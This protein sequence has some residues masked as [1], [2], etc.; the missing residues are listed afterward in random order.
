MPSILE[1]LH[2]ETIGT[3]AYNFKGYNIQQN[4]NYCAISRGTTYAE[5]IPL[6]I[7]VLFHRLSFEGIIST[8]VNEH[9]YDEQHD[10]GILL[11][12]LKLYSPNSFPWVQMTPLILQTLSLAAEKENFQGYVVTFQIG[13]IG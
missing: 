12:G 5:C 10:A 1:L 8:R 6:F 3:S 9:G 7:P 11:T 13:A 4:H 2:I